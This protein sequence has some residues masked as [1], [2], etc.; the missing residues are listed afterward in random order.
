VSDPIDSAINAEHGRQEAAWNERKALEDCVGALQ[1]ILAFYDPNQRHLDT[2]AWKRACAS[3]VHAYRE[4]ATLL[5]WCQRPVAARNGE[6][7]FD[8]EALS[9]IALEQQS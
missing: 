9:I 2:E 3:G 8:K 6:V 4:G 1:F 5:G 7:V